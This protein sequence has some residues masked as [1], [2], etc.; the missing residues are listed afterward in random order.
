[1]KHGKAAMKHLT[2]LLGIL[3]WATATSAADGPAD[4]LAKTV[5]GQAGVRA[6]VCEMPWAGDGKLAASLARLGVAQVHA[7]APDA[8]AADAARKPAAGAGVLGSQVII[9][10]GKPDAL[11]LGDW[12]ADLY[13]VAD[14][15][16]ANL[17]TL[18]ALEAARVLSPYRGVAMVGNPVKGALTR[19]ALEQWAKETGGMAAIRDDAGGLW[20]VVKMPPLKGGDDW[21]QYYHGPDANPVSKDT[22]FSRSTF[23]MQWNSAPI[24][25]DRNYTVVASAGRIFVACCDLFNWSGQFGIHPQ[26]PF[27][28]LAL[29]LYNG[30]V[31]WRRPISGH[32]GDMGPLVVATADRLYLKEEA[33]VLVLNPETGAEM[34]RIQATTP[35]SVVRCIVLADGVLLTMGGPVPFS[36]RLD[37]KN[38]SGEYNDESVND[39]TAAETHKRSQGQGVTAWDA[40]SGTKLWEY[41]GS[42]TR[43]RA[44]VSAGKV[45]LYV[46]DAYATALDLKTGKTLWKTDA[47]SPVPGPGL[48]K[49]PK[50]FNGYRQ[51]Y[52]ARQGDSQTVSSSKAFVIT[53]EF[54]EMFAAFD[55]NDGH[56]LWQKQPHRADWQL[57]HR[58]M[59][60]GD[61]LIPIKSPPL[62]LLTGEMSNTYINPSTKKP[63]AFPAD[64]CGHATSVES[65]LW[66]GGGVVDMKTFD[67]SSTVGFPNFLF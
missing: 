24:Q 48:F 40:A 15:T 29:N 66:I 23:A 27:E 12:V 47:P 43:H 18:P 46:N 17:K 5:L 11:P 49:R 41:A 37:E 20:A 35:P 55:A 64:S 65:G 1:M 52:E 10:T 32:F 34:S 56:I 54:V 31:L 28:L 16:D 8:P 45:F 21:G 67:L 30:S 38:R 50:G 26:H 60:V 51:I 14:A 3:L 36:G 42:I 58:P 13:V 57:P 62:K 2:Y 25:G 7:L 22:A 63:F 59:I 4:A 6:T 9:E 19:S 33:D 61:D 53:D 39:L 44:N